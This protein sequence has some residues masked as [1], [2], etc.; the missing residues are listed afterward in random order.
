MGFSQNSNTKPKSQ[1][2]SKRGL[3]GKQSGGTRLRY[4]KPNKP[5]GLRSGLPGDVFI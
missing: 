1:P 3:T 5:E 2:G 4:V